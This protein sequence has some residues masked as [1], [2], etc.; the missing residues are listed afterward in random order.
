[1]LPVRIGRSRGQTLVVDRRH[2]GVSGHHLAIV[3][4]D[5]NGAQV[6]VHGDNGVNLGGTTRAC[7]AQFHWPVGTTLVLDPPSGAEPACTL[8]LEPPEQL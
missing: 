5:A 4:L 2:A 8:R 3:D 7:G 1:M 6:I